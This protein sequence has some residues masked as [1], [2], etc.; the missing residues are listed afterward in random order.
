MRL[1]P[2]QREVGWCDL[3]SWLSFE[4]IYFLEEFLAALAQF[5]FSFMFIHQLLVTSCQSGHGTIHWPTPADGNY[6]ET[7]TK[8]RCSSHHD[9]E[10]GSK[11]GRDRQSFV[12]DGIADVPVVATNSE[13]GS[14]LADADG[15][16]WKVRQI[17]G[18][19]DT[20]SGTMYKVDW[21]PT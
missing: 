19:R 15:A 13:S 10:T 4:E 9:N 11:Q 1:S 14:S 16:S 7:D 3:F 20:R 6:A 18:K 17:I 12:D 8:T 2:T 5:A 21:M